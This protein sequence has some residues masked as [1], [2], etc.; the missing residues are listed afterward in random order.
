M[1]FL[2]GICL[3][4]LTATRAAAESGI[5][6][7]LRYAPLN[8]PDATVATLSAQA[9]NHIV[10]LNATA[11]SP[12]ITASQELQKAFQGVFNKTIDILYA[13]D[14]CSS[15]I[16]SVKVLIVGTAT[17]FNRL[18]G[19]N[20]S[21]SLVS[22]SD[23]VPD[24]YLWQLPSHDSSLPTLLLGQNER[25]TLYGTFSYLL[26][27]AQGNDP[28]KTASNAT[29]TNGH[30]THIS[31]PAAPVRWVNQWDNLDGSIERGYGGK[32]LFFSG[33]KVVTDLRRAAA[34]ARI[35]ASVGIN[36]VVVNNVNADAALVHTPANIEGLGRIADAF[37]PYGVRVGVSL[38]FASPQ[39]VGGLSTYDPL[40]KSVVSFWDG[41]T[42]QL[43]ERIP[44]LAGFL[45]KGDSEGQPGPKKYGRTLAE[46]ANL[47]ARAL[48]KHSPADSPGILMYRA[49]VYDQ[50]QESN[51]RADRANAAVTYF[52]PLDGQFDDNVVV[53]VKY[54][55]IDFQVREPASPL[56]GHLQKTNAAIELQ[57]TQEYLGQQCHLVYLPP[58]W[59]TVLDFDMGKVDGEPSVVRDIIT[60]ERF[61][62]LLGGSAG[63]VNAGTSDT[64]LGS[65][66][67]QAN[68]Y[69]YGRMAWDPTAGH[70]DGNDNS[71]TLSTPRHIIESWTKLTFGRDPTLVN[72]VADM[73]L[74]SWPA[75]ENYT[76]NLGTQTLTDILYT[77][78]GPNPASQD[79]NGW[80]QWTRADKNGVGMDRTVRNGTGFAGQ[81]VGK[82]VAAQFESV[83]T[84]PRDLLLWFHH[85]PYTQR[86]PGPGE[87]TT[88]IQH[89]YD[90]HYAGAE[91]AALFVTRWAALNASG[92]IDPERYASI[93][94]QLAFQAGHAIV[95]RDAICGF[96][97]G[98]SGIADR[99]DRVRHHPWRIEA[100]AM[101]LHGYTKQAVS[102]AITASGGQAIV[103]AGRGQASASA[104][105]PTSIPPGV[106]TLAV[107]YFDLAGG[108]SSYA[109]QI[110]GKTIGNWT[111]NAEDVFGKATS[112]HLDGHSA[113]RVS[114]LNVVVA[115]GDTVTVLGTP[116]GAEQAALDYVSFLPEGVVD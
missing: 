55:P 15:V 115:A 74:A 22:S 71:S 30:T 101:T 90:A 88:V 31:N 7:W 84:T 95:W 97:A 96:F 9:P 91:T 99:H 43:Y 65:H 36:A 81:Y 18:C 38:N 3:I 104:T 106:Y 26:E 28:A 63:V 61:N 83:E 8:A 77:H 89:I 16:G 20:S 53:Q 12:I 45:V 113:T 24:G 58:L 105:I 86:L 4:A 52:S 23:L 19:N 54:G 42:L 27:L 100:E 76:G 67:A 41:V 73:A 111:G 68:L 2:L 34:Y 87:N 82:E 116:D 103:A 75:Y 108:R 93:A 39:S 110:N 10:V 78:F 72:T 51:W 47:F 37:R 98:L 6:A 21:S 69:A 49:F 44:D 56:F 102:P 25:G 14:N 46:G 57:V 85:V 64:W 60:G 32:S 70:D 80:G 5:D 109:V 50:L 62:R 48:R 112:T 13:A 40:D 17:S 107:N 114:F 94:R 1:R 35:L 92:L 79:G 29:T 33:G 59:R 66:L 11:G